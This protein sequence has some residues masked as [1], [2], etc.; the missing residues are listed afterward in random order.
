MISI[1]Y[2]RC[3]A[4]AVFFILIFLS[5]RISNAQS[6]ERRSYTPE[7]RQ[8]RTALSEI[9]AEKQFQSSPVPG[10]IQ[11][12]L[13]KFLNR[14]KRFIHW[15]NAMWKALQ[16]FLGRIFNP[17]HHINGSV[18][19]LFIFLLLAVLAAPAIWLLRK[20]L[21]NRPTRERKK[22]A[23]TFSFVEESRALAAEHD[24]DG[25]LNHAKTLADAGE[26]GPAFRTLFLAILQKLAIFQV[27]QWT[28][29]NTNG[30]YLD[31]LESRPSLFQLIMPISSKFDNIY[32]GGHSASEK[33]YKQGLEI[34][35]QI[36]KTLINSSNGK[37]DV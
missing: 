8:V 10:S 9:L 6:S 34:Y 14:A 27:V 33:D 20:L 30:E 18:G 23:R 26:Y 16:R 21:I 22:E 11:R 3:I 15:I 36:G 7:P 13:K 28:N 29:G 2:P 37:E 5:G 12:I 25:L 31:V 24:P 19:R 1:R 32:Y 35:L 17:S 4:L